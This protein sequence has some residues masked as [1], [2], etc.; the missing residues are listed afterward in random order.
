MC[1]R[2]RA[3]LAANP[4]IYFE[5]FSNSP[6]YFMTNSGCSSGAEDASSDNL[7]T[8]MYDDFA[9]YIAEATK[10]MKQQGINFQSYSPM[11]ERCV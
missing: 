8:D 5:G 10:L 1:I 11:N 3:A 4:N 2:D 9:K 7:R 6:P